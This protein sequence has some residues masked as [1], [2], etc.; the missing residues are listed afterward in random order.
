M[1]LTSEYCVRGTM[2]TNDQAITH[3]DDDLYGFDPFAA[4]IAKSIANMKTPEGVV[5]AINGV[6]G[7][8][9]TSVLNL[10]TEKLKDQTNIEVAPFN[11]WWFSTSEALT[12]GFLR[13][14][15]PKNWLKYADSVTD[16]FRVINPKDFRVLA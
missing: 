1:S 8:G 11:P 2:P 13:E 7:S 9:K 12:V 16:N 6:W 5:I 15:V 3:H 4:A 14:E 10:I